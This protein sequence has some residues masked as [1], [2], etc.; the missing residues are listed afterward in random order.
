V[1]FPKTSSCSIF[2]PQLLVEPLV[3]TGLVYLIFEAT[4]AR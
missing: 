4:K 3:A 2:G 1:I